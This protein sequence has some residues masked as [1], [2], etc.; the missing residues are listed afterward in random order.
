VIGVLP[1]SFDNVL[2]PNAEIY[3]PI[4]YSMADGSACRTC[5][6]LVMIGRVKHGIATT[7]AARELDVLFKR[8]IAEHPREYSTT[9]AIAVPLQ[10]AIT[11]ANRTVLLTLLGA[12]LLVLLIAAAN[13]TNL[14]LARAVRREGE[15]AVRAALGAGRGRIVQQLVAEGI[16]IA[17]LGGVAGTLLA[18][19]VLPVLTAQLPPDM[20]RL[21]AIAVDWRALAAV[22]SVVLAMGVAVGL[23]SAFGGRLRFFDTLRS[24]RVVSGSRH[25]TRSALVVA[26]VALAL[27]LVIGSGLLARS[28]RRLLDVDPGFDATHLVTMEVQASGPAYQTAA[29]VFA[30]HDRVREAVRAVPGV[31]DAGLATMLPLGGNYDQ[32]GVH[33]EDKPSENP[34]LDPSADRYVVSAGFLSAMRIPVVRGRAFTEAEAADSNGN[35]IIVSKALAERIW[36]G[37]D[38][39]ARRIRIGGSERPW[40]TVI[41]VA[42]DIRHTSLA[43]QTYQF[44]VP[45]RQW[46]GEEN[47]MALV[48]RVA[49][50]PA[51]LSGAIREAVRSADPLQPIAKIATMETVVSRSTS[52]RRLGLML[53]VAFGAIALVLAAA[54]IY[55]VLSGS[56]AE[57]TREFGL[58]GALGAV[59]GSIVG[60]ILRQ[61]AALAGAGFLIGVAAAMALSRYL[62]S[63]L[64]GVGPTDPVAVGIAVVALGLVALAACVL[65]AR[66]AMRVDPMS[67]LRSD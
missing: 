51:A 59:P 31:I 44:Y 7:E 4:G 22:A 20:P 63:L 14:Q 13:V 52:Q 55:G 40:K 54:G 24:A 46:Y 34:E 35:V 23:V 6:H 39:L 11:R 1:A 66:R 9:G 30:N 64:Y 21:S 48:V 53:F 10:Q 41:G 19:T 28:L 47:V 18:V 56:V 29:S 45:E 43:D 12:A 26:E 58:R 27:M 65:P 32:H 15:F 33:A 3:R 25:R 49:G 16:V 62:R 8:V 17:V 37:E 2:E 61:A 36:P 60:L 50:D 5:R 57:R 67:A 38:P 42:A